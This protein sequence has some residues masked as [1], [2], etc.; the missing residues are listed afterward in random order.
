MN[1]SQITS[2]TRSPNNLDIF[3]VQSSQ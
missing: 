1:N 2:D 3:V